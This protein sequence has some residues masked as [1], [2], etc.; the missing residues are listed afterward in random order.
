MQSL[1]TQAMVEI[2]PL[3]LDVPWHVFTPTF[4]YM[5]HNHTACSAYILLNL[6]YAQ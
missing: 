3:S 6:Y 2:L 1:C 4:S 5:L